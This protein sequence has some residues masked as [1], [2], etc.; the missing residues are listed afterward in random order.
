MSNVL[1][2]LEAEMGIQIVSALAN[3]HSQLLTTSGVQLQE[4]QEKYKYGRKIAFPDPQTDPGRYVEEMFSQWSAGRSHR[5]PTWRH[6]LE[7][8][9]NIGLPE[10]SQQIDTFMKGKDWSATNK[11]YG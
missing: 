3:N 8:L 1:S 11:H 9:R 2:R 10:L 4:L 7:V 6:L 5:L